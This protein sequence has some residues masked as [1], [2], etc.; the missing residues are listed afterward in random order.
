MPGFRPQLHRRCAYQLQQACQ[1]LPQQ[2]LAF[3]TAQPG[4]MVGHAHI[5]HDTTQALHH[6]SIPLATCP[7][8]IC[9]LPSVSDTRDECRQQ[10]QGCMSA[11]VSCISVADERLGQQGDEGGRVQDAQ[12]VGAGGR[13]A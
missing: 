6:C 7:A 4:V 9:R 2:L 5:P 10:V 3:E 12:D 1:R 13:P 11:A 8:A